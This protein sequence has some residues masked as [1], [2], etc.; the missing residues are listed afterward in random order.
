ML[1]SKLTQYL[2]VAA[3]LA[4]L[5]GSLYGLVAAESRWAWWTSL[6]VYTSVLVVSSYAF[7]IAASM[8]GGD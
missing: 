3:W 5:A 4:L 7:L 1:D 2:I 8:I 6:A